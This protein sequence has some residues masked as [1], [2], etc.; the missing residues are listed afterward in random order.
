MPVMDGVTATTEIRKLPGFA[1]LPIVAMT[2]NAMQQD[3]E[4]CLAAGMNDHLAK[5]IE[6]NDLL[7]A[8]QKWINPDNIKAPLPRKQTPTDAPTPIPTDIEGLDTAL[9]LR[10]MQGKHIILV[11]VK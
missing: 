7:A 9:G 6:P 11:D 2:A 8:L 5:P 1:E 3:R 10:R 4:R